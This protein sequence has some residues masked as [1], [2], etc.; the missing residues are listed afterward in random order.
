MCLC[1]VGQYI[2]D[3]A[4]IFGVIVYMEDLPVLAVDRD[5]GYLV[6]VTANNNFCWIFA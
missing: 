5:N 6:C 1:V 2:M 4:V 3:L